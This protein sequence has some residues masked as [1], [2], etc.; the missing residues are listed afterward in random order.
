MNNDHSP[1]HF[2]D[3]VHLLIR[4]KV[5]IGL[6]LF[7]SMLAT[8]GL[9]KFLPKK[10]KS[11]SIINVYSK[12]FK[13][14][15]VSEVIPELHSLEEIRYNINSLIRQAFDDKFID[16]IAKEFDLYKYAEGNSKR[17]FERE[18]IRNKG[19]EILS[20]SPQTFR[21]SYIGEKPFL[22][23]KIAEKGVNQVILHLINNR[24]DSIERV[25]KAVKKRIDAL[26]IAKEETTNPMISKNQA[27]L[28]DEIG[29][30]NKSIISLQSQYSDRHPLV[31][32]LIEKKRIL[33]GWSDGKDSSTG[34][35][36]L[37]ILGVKSK[38]I[39]DELL[40]ELLR[41][42][43]YLNIILDVE[44]KQIPDYMGV[45]Q[46]A[47]VP[48]SPIWPKPITV[49]SVGLLM[50]L[51]LSF[52][53]VFIIELLTDDLESLQ[54]SVQSQLGVQLLGKL[55]YVERKDTVLD[56]GNN[57]NNPKNKKS[58]LSDWN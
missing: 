9:S 27:V 49:F 45:I 32:T 16:S 28:K 37:P 38:K 2:I 11:T 30:V 33:E 10:Y 57:K 52:C 5:Q 35:E 39:I 43:N 22:V 7:I 42:Y 3:V 44:D 20:S 54:R 41:K 47:S 29:R 40:K 56:N 17:N 58:N 26:Y 14:P 12:Y 4:K 8:Y 19:F 1:M 21:I 24:K 13:N 51:I 53:Y 36:Q 25:R 15:M 34:K 55:P 48:S 50:G 23:K 31:A 6:I 46:N 18:S